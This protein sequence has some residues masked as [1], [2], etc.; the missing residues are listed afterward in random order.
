MLS[1]DI[2]L[3]NPFTDGRY[4]IDRLLAFT[5]DH[6]ERLRA[7]NLGGA[8]PGRIAATAAALAAFNG[9]EVAHS[10]SLGE[11][12]T[13]KRALREFRRALGERV[14]A[15]HLALQVKYGP[16]AAEL[17]TFFPKGRTA[18]ARCPDD[19]LEPLLKALAAAIAERPAELGPELAATAAGLVAD[20][21]PLHATSMAATGAK[22]TAEFER[23]GARVALERELYLNLLA[24]AQEFPE[25]PEKLPAYMHQSLL[26]RKRS[27]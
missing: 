16:R 12:K 10:S 2:Y 27:Q 26:T 24:L 18:F 19:L 22:K 4:G 25:Q 7:A 5:T 11:R 15:L 3:K 21:Q 6:L 13:S 8:W 20:W 1:L 17:K 14:G 23:R 9:Q